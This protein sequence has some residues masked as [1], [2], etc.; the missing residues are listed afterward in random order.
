MNKIC[1]VSVTNIDVWRR[2]MQGSNLWQAV[3]PLSHKYAL[4]LSLLL[5]SYALKR[6][7]LEVKT[8]VNILQQEEFPYPCWTSKHSELQVKRQLIAWALPFFWGG[9]K[10]ILKYDPIWTGPGIVVQASLRHTS[11]I[12]SS[13]SEMA[14]SEFCCVPSEMIPNLFKIFHRALVMFIL[15]WCGNFFFF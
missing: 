5:K 14:S 9:G 11:C 13:V 12:S 7:W 6:H 8:R 10:G 1:L 4:T 3:D 2:K 15:R